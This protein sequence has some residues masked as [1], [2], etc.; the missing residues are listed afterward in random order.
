[1]QHKYE[2]VNDIENSYISEQLWNAITSLSNYTVY[3]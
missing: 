2:N 1:L 3:I